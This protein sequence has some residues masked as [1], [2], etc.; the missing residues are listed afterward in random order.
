MALE[1]P[2]TS[3]DL[4]IDFASLLDLSVSDR[5]QAAASDTGFAQALIASLTPIQLAK[6]FPDYYRKELPDISNFILANRYLDDVGKGGFDQQGGG[7]YGDNK[8][9]YD[10]ETATPAGQNPIGVPEPTIEE[11]QAK[12]L[13]KGIDVNKTYDA[14]ANGLSADDPQIQFLKNMSADKL[15]AM[16]IE[17]FKDDDGKVML[18][19]APELSDQEISSKYS[20]KF[21]AK[22]DATEKQKAVIDFANRWNISP[23][24]AAGVLK[25]ESGVTSDIARGASG[26]YHGVFQLQTEQISGLTKKA[27]FGSLTPAQ[28]RKLSVADQLKVMDEYY[29]QAGI[30]PEFFTGDP[31]TDASKMWALQ[32]APGKAKKID[33][34][35]PNAV[36]SRSN[37]ASTIG[38]RNELVTVG[39]AGKGSI[40]GGAEFLGDSLTRID[41]NATPEQIAE[42]R[43]QEEKLQKET[44]TKE[45]FHE[46][47]PNSLEANQTPATVPVDLEKAVSELPKKV[48]ENLKS[49]P[50]NIKALETATKL[51]TDED[52]QRLVADAATGKIN[53]NSSVVQQALKFKG[54]HEKRDREALTKYLN[55]DP[56]GNK[57]A[58]CAAFVNATL[59][60]QGIKGTG[61]SWAAGDFSDYGDQV[62]DPKN[63]K[64]GDIIVNK[65]MSPRTGK[66][67]SHVMI[68]TGPAYKDKNGKW[69]IPT[70][71]GNTTDKQSHEGDTVAEYPV[72]F[73]TMNVRTVPQEKEYYTEEGWQ[74]LQAKFEQNELRQQALDQDQ[75]INDQAN[76]PVAAATPVAEPTPVPDTKPE[77]NFT[78]PNPNAIDSKPA[79]KPPEPTQTA[80][81]APTPVGPVGGPE[82]APKFRTGGSPDVQ[83]DENLSVFDEDGSLKWKMNSGEGI[84]VK[85]K[86]TEYADDKMD[87]LSGRVDDIDQKTNT[88]EQ[89]QP[90]AAPDK[91]TP[92]PERN[93][94][95]NASAVTYSIGSQGRAFKRTKFQNEGFHF[96]R[97]SPNSTSS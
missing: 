51:G 80:E 19:K 89:N 61:N 90:K 70:I 22:E 74:N 87:E 33:Y 71:S 13:E 6:A 5:V 47:A 39:S 53:P 20:G 73:D 66:I 81:A 75:Q 27:G 35:D 17:Q 79:E 4:T 28:Y 30:T 48:Q 12:L 95:Q 96:S 62:G 69:M 57:R 1:N 93:W 88:P 59:Q 42:F 3:D 67:G 68:A 23:Q 65:K 32:L 91:A 14:I 97:S 52:V 31:Q 29:K 86:D 21:V 8:P 45:K 94:Q 76:V 16:G 2:I 24:A 54:M 25:I 36:I 34:N 83:D 56:V 58:W 7:D 44:F 43:K 41:G 18:R 78:V 49:D 15:A 84:Y 37:Q 82:E 77:Q 50:T 63:V 38:A 10:G 72:A 9:L 40:A 85:P 46:A 92:R 55:G 64:A 11:M 60:S 26:N